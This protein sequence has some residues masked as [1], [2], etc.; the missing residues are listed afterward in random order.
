MDIL[1]ISTT[2]ISTQELFY[3]KQE[4]SEIQVNY[5]RMTIAFVLF[6]V[7]YS[8]RGEALSRS[9]QAELIGIAIVFLS[10]AIAL[11]YIKF[12]GYQR[13]IKYIIPYWTY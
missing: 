1:G 6:I 8:V 13:W 3:S 11:L 9:F 5:L 10:G 7:M 4:Q 2:T 12:I